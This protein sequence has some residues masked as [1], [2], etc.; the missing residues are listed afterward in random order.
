M[1]RRIAPIGVVLLGS[2]AAMACGG[3]VIVQGPVS[4]GPLDGAPAGI[5]AEVDLFYQD[6]APHGSWVRLEGP[7]LVWYPRGVPADWRPYALGR[8]AYSDFGWTWVSDED[9]GWAVYHYGRWHR[10]PSYGWVW[11]PG[12]EWGP[13]WV[14]WHTGGGWIGWAPLPWQVRWRAGVG[15][16][17]GN[18]DARVAINPGSWCFVQTR[19]LTAPSP[20]RYFAPAARNVSLIKVTK[21]VTNYTIVDNRVFN[22]GVHVN[23]VSKAT[24]R[25]V[26]QVRVRQSESPEAARGDRQAGED[27]LVFR[28]G[29]RRGHQTA[30]PH[31][32]WTP[33]GRARS[34]PA[35]ERYRTE[36][37]PEEPE[38][39][40]P[41]EPPRGERDAR[42]AKPGRDGEPDQARER[43]QS[44]GRDQREPARPKEIG[45]PPP[46]SPKDVNRTHDPEPSAPEPSTPEARPD[47]GPRSSGQL[48]KKEQGDKPQVSKRPAKESKPGASKS[49]KT[50]TEGE[51][52]DKSDEPDPE[53]KPESKSE[54]DKDKP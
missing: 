16:D 39:V 19:H 17:W 6:L 38:T 12:S 53:S 45:G 4:Y 3:G 1:K 25:P 49:R 29:Q 11:V 22:Q 30:G 18:V 24:G 15:L 28:P 7:G 20:G 40:R 27:L 34:V 47:H 10:D 36:T 9:W 50:R 2:L 5:S 32:G 13:A 43:A 21:N 48:Q 26:R 41:Q 14:T 8:W 37:T 31:T 33:P 44:R 42:E 52:P 46:G 54:S 23:V 35:R 51:D